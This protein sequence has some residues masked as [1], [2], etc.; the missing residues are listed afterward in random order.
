MTQQDFLNIA[1]IYP[2]T[3]NVWYTDLNVILGL[4]V[5]VLTATS[6]AE[7][8]LPILQQVETITLPVNGTDSVVLNILTRSIQSVIVAGVLKQ[9][10]FFTV[11]PTQIGTAETVI[12]NG[13]VIFEPGYSGVAF[14]AS[15]YDVLEGSVEDQR[16]SAYIMKAEETNRSIQYPLLPGNIDALQNNTAERSNT[17][18]SNYSTT[19]WIRG[20]YDG[21]KT[22]RYNYGTI[23]PA[24]TG[25]IFNGSY[26]ANN[27]TDGMIQSQ[28]A[29]DTIYENYFYS[30]KQ[31]IP[32]PTIRFSGFELYTGITTRQQTTFQIFTSTVYSSF[33]VTEFPGAYEADNAHEEVPNKEPVNP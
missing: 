2:D 10:Y 9:Y 24:I 7:D 8:I 17:Q 18:D 23:D 33:T 6:P 21:T 5:P 4:T 3:L 31:D 19:G 28:S 16:V 15:G 26:F 25:K 27:V 22:D 11:T 29:T 14:I 30:S 32:T 1:E 12:T 20:R 13:Q